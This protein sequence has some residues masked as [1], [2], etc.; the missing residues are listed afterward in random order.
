MPNGRRLR[1]PPSGVT[2]AIAHLTLTNGRVEP[3]DARGWGSGGGIHNVGNLTL[4]NINVNNSVA[5]MGGGIATVDLFEPTHDDAGAGGGL[6]N[7]DYGLLRV[8]SSD[9]DSN[10]V[11][12][13]GGGVQNSEGWG[14]PARLWVTGTIIRGNYASGGDGINT[15]ATADIADS[16][17]SG[18]QARGASDQADGLGGSIRNTGTLRVANS[19]VNGNYASGLERQV[20]R[21][22]RTI[23]LQDPAGLGRQ[24]KLL[25]Q[26]LS[27]SP[28]TIAKVILSITFFWP[29][30][31]IICLA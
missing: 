26:M 12:R 31:L 20:R 11:E 2:A 25:R 7:N 16:N 30:L 19:T 14:S 22:Y 8:E 23:L 4:D 21:P 29:N 3:S 5:Y 17:I 27:P 28:H 6:Y 15:N 13:F 1:H 9:I 18:N 10:G 24:T